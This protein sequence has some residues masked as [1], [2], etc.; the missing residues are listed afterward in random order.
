MPTKKRKETST[1]F[2]FFIYTDKE[3]NSFATHSLTCHTLVRI[4]SIPSFMFFS[5]HIRSLA[6][7]KVLCSYDKNAICKKGK[8]RKPS[9]FHSTLL[10]G[11]KKICDVLKSLGILRSFGRYVSGPAMFLLYEAY[12]LVRERNIAE[13]LEAKHCQVNVCTT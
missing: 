8:E 12:I 2:L 7:N 6:N 9:A 1:R 5:F 11:R 4:F 3:D 10:Q 13:P